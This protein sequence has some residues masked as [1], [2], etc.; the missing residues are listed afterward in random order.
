MSV[1]ASLHAGKPRG[2]GRCNAPCQRRTGHFT[3]PPKTLVFA[4]IAHHG[5]CP[6]LRAPG[7]SWALLHSLSHAEGLGRPQR[8]HGSGC[9]NAARAGR[10]R[11]R[12]AFL[13]AK[14]ASRPIGTSASSSQFNIIFCRMDAAQGTPDM[15]RR[16]PGAIEPRAGG[17]AC[18][19]PRRTT[20]RR[21]TARRVRRAGVAV[22]R[23]FAACAGGAAQGA[24]WADAGR[25]NTRSNTQL[26]A[27]V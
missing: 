1:V 5:P 16:T 2:P 19:L 18:P 22:Q 23:A 27:K 12:S 14:W 21:R 24:A 13:G 15:C 10:R 3:K 9:A 6:M 7:R 17:T 8:T 25:P 20:A 4:A 11:H 26:K